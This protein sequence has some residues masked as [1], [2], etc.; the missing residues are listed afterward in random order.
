MTADANARIQGSPVLGELQAHGCAKSMIRRQ[1]A[2]TLFALLG[3]GPSAGGQAC[4]LVD[5]GGLER[6]G[7]NGR[8]ELA[9]G[10]RIGSRKR[11]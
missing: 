3:D 2:D 10:G 5:M 1:P 8:S 11:P 6:T 4:S 7:R 9:G